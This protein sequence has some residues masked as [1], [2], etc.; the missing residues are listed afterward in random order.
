M[1]RCRR[2]D[3]GMTTWIG[4]LRAINL[5]A[6]RKFPKDRIVA[7]VEAAGGTGVATYINTGNVRFEHELDDRAAVE[8]VLEKAFEAEVGFAVPTVCVSPVELVE[9]A[10]AATR[11]AHAGKHYVSLLKQ[12]PSAESIALLE[13]R[14]ADGE[15]LAVVGR[16]VHLML[17]ENYH[18]AKLTNTVVEKHLGVATN[19]NLTVIAT[20]AEK[21]GVSGS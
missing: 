21:W 5:G 3:A 6:T 4:F 20:L 11:L 17:G 18:Q 13:A 7:A 14:A 1:Y 19:R 2:D 12:E 9:I 16:G 8:L 10:A 15:T